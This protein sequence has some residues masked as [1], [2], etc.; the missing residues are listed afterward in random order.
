MTAFNINDKVRVKLT[1]Y[2]RE[3]LKSDHELFWK[4]VGKTMEYRPPKEDENGW[5]TWQ[6]WSLMHYLGEHMFLGSKNV[7]ETDI[8]FKPFND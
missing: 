6:L 7:I 8:Q 4:S 5:S 2:G 1:D 3:V